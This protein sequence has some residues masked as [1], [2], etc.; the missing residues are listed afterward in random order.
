M[1]VRCAGESLQTPQEASEVLNGGNM[2]MAR[3]PVLTLAAS[4]IGLA[5]KSYA[6]D[7]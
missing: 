1:A 6:V 2:W 5:K 7:S 4:S 3:V